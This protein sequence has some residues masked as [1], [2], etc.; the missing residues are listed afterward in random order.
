MKKTA[1]CILVLIL[2]VFLISH[3]TAGLNS[4]A[5]VRLKKAGVSDQT[6]QVIVKEKAIETAAFSVQEIVDMKQAGL[7]EETIRMVITESSFLR[8]SS[9][10]VYGEKI[11]TIQFTSVQDIIELKNAGISDDVIQ[12]ILAVVGD[13]DKSERQE[14]LE[15]LDKMKIRIDLRGR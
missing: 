10:I 15:F 1:F 8:D 12:A 2:M 11:R 9:P 7:S 5:M 13:S 4:E 3:P 14:A 6:I